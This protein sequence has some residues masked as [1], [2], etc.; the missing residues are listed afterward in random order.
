MAS[1]VKFDN[2]VKH[3]IDGKIAF[4]TDEFKALLTN[5]APVVTNNLYG[6]ISAAQVANG[7]GY[8]TGGATLTITTSVSG[9]GP[10]TAKATVTSD[11][12]FTASGALGPFRYIVVYDN[13]TASPAKPLWCMYDYASSVT[14]ATGETFTLDFDQ[15]A[16]LFTG[17]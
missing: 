11:I 14:L 8:T 9:S 16:G 3:L 17:T 13:T 10:A 5:T 6:D 15:S 1:Y 4:G 7:N 2:G 12:T